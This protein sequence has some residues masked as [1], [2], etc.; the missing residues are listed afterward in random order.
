MLQKSYVIDPT[1]E[2]DI[3]NGTRHLNRPRLFTVIITFQIPPTELLLRCFTPKV[4]KSV[5]HYF[6]LPNTSKFIYVLKYMYKKCQQQYL[7]TYL[8]YL[9]W[10]WWRINVCYLTLFLSCQIWFSLELHFDIMVHNISLY[11]VKRKITTYMHKF[12]SFSI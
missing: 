9:V 12:N 8:I 10:W 2:N 6:F 5:L 3:L 4:C 7:K 1:S 11:F